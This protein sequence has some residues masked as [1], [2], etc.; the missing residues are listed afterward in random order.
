MD[1]VI[2]EWLYGIIS[3]DLYDIVFSRTTIVRHVWLALEEQF[4]GNRESR[5]LHLDAEFHNFVL[6]D[7]NVS[8]YCHCL[9][10]MAGALADLE[11]PVHDRTLMLVVLRGL[12]ESFT[13]T[14]SL[15]KQQ[16]PFPTFNEV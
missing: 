10:G 11:E 9:K 2:L 4:I 13:Y 14:T 7:L 6:G 16:Q 3:S 1:F 5:A 15:L 8:D 12:N